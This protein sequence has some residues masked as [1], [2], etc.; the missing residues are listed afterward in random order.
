VKYDGLGA[1]LA[2]KVL[3]A[4]RVAFA[5]VQLFAASGAPTYV[6]VLGKIRDGETL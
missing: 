6:V 3:E 4:Q 5:E 2:I 1:R